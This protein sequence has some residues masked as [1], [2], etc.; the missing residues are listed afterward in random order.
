MDTDPPAPVP[1]TAV[2]M[3]QGVH[4][5]PA[6]EALGALKASLRTVVPARTVPLERAAGRILAAPVVALRPHPPLTNA[7]VD[8]Y[9][10]AHGAL[11][12]PPYRMAV[13]AGV[14]A[15]AGGAANRA[16]PHGMAV[17]ILTGAPLPA[18]VDTVV[19]EESTRADGENIVFDGPVRAGANTRMAAEDCPAGAPLLDAG[20]ILRPPDLALLALT[21][22]GRVRVRRKLRVGVLSTGNELAP[23]GAPIGAG[24]IADA[25]GPM[26][27]TLVAGWGMV[28]VDLGR[29]PDDRDALHAHLSDAAT[30]CDALLTSG[31]ASAGAADHVSAL[32]AAEG[33]T[34]AWRIAI[35]PGR[36]L[37]LGFWKGCPFFGLPGNPVAAFVTAVMFARPGL[38]VLAGAGWREADAIEVRADFSKSKQAGRREYLRA[39]LCKGRARVFP[40]EG[41]GRVSGLTWANGLVELPDHDLDITPG[42]I[43][44]FVP[45]SNLMAL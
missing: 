19:L 15:A 28:P 18:G 7:A 5:T 25:N 13:L 36:P 14:T 20:H 39:H 4:W 32:L 41:S 6:S 27:R 11:G 12:R 44:R 3:P 9:G 33:R 43:V 34:T 26:L 30:R 16:V 23:P 8:G 31:G 42:D 38:S 22:H 37:A 35:K 29:V 24:Q 21:G 10:F 1:R 2:S 45:Y 17:R 40:S